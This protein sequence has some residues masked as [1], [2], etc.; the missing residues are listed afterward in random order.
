MKLRLISTLI[1][2]FSVAGCSTGNLNPEPKTFVRVSTDYQADAGGHP[3]PAFWYANTTLI[4]KDSMAAADASAA[5]D[6]AGLPHSVMGDYLRIKP[7]I[8][9]ALLKDG[10]N[11]PETLLTVAPVT[12]V[13]DYGGVSY[14]EGYYPAGPQIN[15][16]T[17]K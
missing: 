1:A 3:V 13:F 15:A 2:M 6:S 12:R 9:S 16:S 10:D 4:R 11:Q 17:L 14:H 5:L 7:P 8:I